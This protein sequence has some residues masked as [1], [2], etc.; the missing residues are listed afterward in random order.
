MPYKDKE[1]RKECKK[2]YY[3][4]HK[5]ELKERNRKYSK[6]HRKQKREWALKNKDKIKKY[7]KKYYEKNKGEINSKIRKHCRHQ[8][9]NTIINGKPERILRLNKREW[10]GYCELCGKEVKKYLHYHHWDDENLNIG[11]WLCIYC[12]RFAERVDKGIKVSDY[13]RLKE[14]VEKEIRERDKK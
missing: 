4:R 3:E 10:T 2:R 14:M 7:S 5:E 13:E 11:L 12:H 9:L 8:H 1:K 6:E